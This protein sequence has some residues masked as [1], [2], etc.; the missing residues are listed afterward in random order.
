M[1]EEFLFTPEAQNEWLKGF[2]RPVLQEKMIAGGTID[3]TALA[4][5]A[6]VKG[7]PVVLTEAQQKA[8]ADYVNKNW[9]IALP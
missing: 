8:A 3:Q 4:S 7:T 2:A 1:W 6:Q 9:N 5:L